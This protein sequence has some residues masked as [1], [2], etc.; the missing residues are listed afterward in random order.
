[1]QHTSRLRPVLF[2]A[3]RSQIESHKWLTVKVKRKD[4]RRFSS[5]E[6]T[7]LPSYIRRTQSQDPR[8]QATCRWP[9]KPPIG[10]VKMLE[11]TFIQTDAV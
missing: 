6:M 11:E 3:F 10:T 5:T 1:M 4:T 2:V 9:I 7:K 8:S